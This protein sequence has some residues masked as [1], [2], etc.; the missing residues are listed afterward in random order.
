MALDLEGDVAMDVHVLGRRGGG[1]AGTLLRD[2]ALF[3]SDYPNVK[4][5]RRL[6]DFTQFSFTDDVRP[7]TLK[8]NAKQ[9]LGLTSCES[10]A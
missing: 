8:E 4:P 7:L 9:L 5:E 1:T 3:G 6:T 2:R 10:V